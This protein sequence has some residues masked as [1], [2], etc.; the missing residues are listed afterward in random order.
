MFFFDRCSSAPP[1]GLIA[2]EAAGR[3]EAGCVDGWPVPD[4]RL[5]GCRAAGSAAA[6]GAVRRLA[7]QPLRRLQ[8]GGLASRQGGPGGCSKL[9]PS[10]DRIT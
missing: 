8:E 2:G 7:G 3:L 6:G 10:V 9:F 1:L 5:G 4:G